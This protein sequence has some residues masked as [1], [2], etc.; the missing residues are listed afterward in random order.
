MP[1]M[2]SPM[3]SSFAA[4]CIATMAIRR[5]YSYMPMERMPLTSNAR[6][7]GMTPTGVTS[8]NATMKHHA[9]ADLRAEFSANALPRIT[10]YL[11]PARSPRRPLSRCGCPS[12]RAPRHPALRRATARRR[13]CRRGSAYLFFDVRR[14]ADD[15]REMLEFSKSGRQFGMRPSRPE[16]VACAVRLKI[17]VRNS[18]SKPFMTDKT[19]MS[20]ATPSARPDDRDAGDQR[21]EAALG[22]SAQVSQSQESLH[23]SRASF[24]P[25]ALRRVEFCE[26]FRPDRP[27]RR[28]SAAGR[29]RRSA[30][31]RPGAPRSAVRIV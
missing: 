13:T 8:P 19:T 18:S 24:V 31:R 5:S 7:R 2:S 10:R 21:D 16:I 6:I 9:I 14:R 22:G 20:T 25:Q 29:P 15:T 4:S 23:T 12:T 30:P 1:V 11:P 26:A 17:R 27:W 28:R 3:R